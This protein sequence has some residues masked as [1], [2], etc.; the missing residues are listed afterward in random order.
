MVH[1]E[2]N[3][4]A[5]LS[6]KHH[7]KVAALFKALRIAQGEDE[8]REA[9]EKL[10]NFLEAKSAQALASLEEA[11]GEMI[12]FFKLNVPNTLNTSFLSANGIGNTFRNT[13]RK[14]NRVTRWR[15]ETE[16]ASNWLAYALLTAEKGFNRL[17]GCS[18][19][20][21]LMESLK[22]LITA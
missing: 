17:R 18:E 14:I 3:I 10:L 21:G 11:D 6:H 5:K 13:R 4:K 1:K 15:E 7:G 19:M 9:L 22:T 16:Q 12:A 20:P 2:R 8:A